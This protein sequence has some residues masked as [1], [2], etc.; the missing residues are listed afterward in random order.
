MQVFRLF[1]KLIKNTSAPIVA[2]TVFFVL[3]LFI[4]MDKGNYSFVEKKEINLAVLNYNMED[5]IWEQ[6]RL[7]LDNYC[8]IYDYEDDEELLKDKMTSFKIDAIIT[9]PY[10]FGN[11]IRKGKKI[12]LEVQKISNNRFLDYIEDL[13][14]LY[15]N[16]TY[17]YLKANEN[18]TVEQLIR[19]MNVIFDTS[20]EV[21]LLGQ[22]DTLIDYQLYEQYFRIAAYVVFTVCFI[23]IGMALHS[24][25]NIHIQRRNLM[26]PLPDRFRNFQMSL[27]NI[28]F[29][30]LYDLIIIIISLIYYT[31]QHLDIFLILFWINLF[32]FSLS[33]LSMSFLMAMLTKKREINIIIAIL[34]PFILCFISG[35][36]STQEEL[37]E[38]LL[39]VAYFTPT[40]WFV[41]GNTTIMNS[42][43]SQMQVLTVIPVILSQLLFSIAT[44]CITLM[45][46]KEKRNKS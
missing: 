41:K 20:G 12:A 42:G 24:F 31:P 4:F 22:K 33:S 9:V 13:V 38:G 28:I 19:S 5:P 17:E 25:Q 14:N 46:S 3:Y 39:R 21:K 30:A 27:G 16:T 32:V 23:G 2:I 35:V 10:G 34:L 6:L 1:F 43:Y 7:L 44:F 11:D 29:V 45:I 15:Q 26:S 18:I 8:R 37:G 36:F 40:Y